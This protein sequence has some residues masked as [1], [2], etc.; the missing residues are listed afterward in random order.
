MVPFPLVLWR[1]ATAG[2]NLAHNRTMPA[3]NALRAPLVHFATN[4]L[5]RL[6]YGAPMVHVACSRVAES[7]RVR[8]GVLSIRRV[9]RPALVLSSSGG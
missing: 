5:K 6:F 3:A 9:H 8:C 4:R 1:E 2:R 7:A